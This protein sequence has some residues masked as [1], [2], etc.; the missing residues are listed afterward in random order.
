MNKLISLLLCIIML[1]STCVISNAAYEPAHTKDADALYELGLFKGMGTDA[2]GNPIYGLEQKATR[3]QGIILLL[4]LLG[5]EAE[6]KEFEGTHPFTDV[7]AWGSKHVAYAYAKGYTAGTSATTFGSNNPL[8]GKAYATFVLKALGYDANSDFNYN[9]AL[10]TA[11]ELGLIKPGECNGELYRDHCVMLSHNALKTNMK[12]SDQTLAEKLESDGVIPSDAL[13]DSKVLEEEITVPL[14]SGMIFFDDVAAAVPGAYIVSCCGDYGN[15]T[16]N[17]VPW[18]SQ[19]VLL[20][21]LYGYSGVS[22][23]IH[24]ESNQLPKTNV[25]TGIS[26]HSD[27]EKGYITYITVLNDQYQMIA[28][29][30]LP[31]NFSGDTITLTTCQIGSKEE[32]IQMKE[33][34]SNI[35]KFTAN[36]FYMEAYTTIHPDGSEEATGYLHIDQSKMP[37]ALKDAVYYTVV[38]GMDY[39]NLASAQVGFNRFSSIHTEL[40][41]LLVVGEAYK[42][43]PRTTIGDDSWYV[44]LFD[45]DKNVIAVV[46]QT[47]QPYENMINHVTDLR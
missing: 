12:G 29:A 40:G 23:Y 7:P 6:A 45:K 2:N 35:K 42:M 43:H 34:I 30:V 10:D 16:Y 27:I 26:F 31:P 18:D 15:Y 19:D 20:T 38:N 4:H 41:D 24:G 47:A 36:I 14:Q 39:A 37:S 9:T 25:K 33:R 21:M 8:L 13:Q 5:E 3:I 46:E 11:A 44:A 1:L 22:E 32:I 28:Y 17:S